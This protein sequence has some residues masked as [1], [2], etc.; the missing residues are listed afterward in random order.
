MTFGEKISKIRKA[1]KLSQLAVANT[2][3]VS[4]DAISKYE[5]D[6]ITPSV[7]TA[8][9]IAKVLNV[10]L[11]YLVS[12]EDK[13]ETLAADMVKRIKEVQNLNKEDKDTIVKIIDAFVRDAK[14]RKTYV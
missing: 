14:T 9:K 6:D 4:R 2:V 7:A 12:D 8:K 1:K 11:D 5:R 3:G 13:Q 10:S